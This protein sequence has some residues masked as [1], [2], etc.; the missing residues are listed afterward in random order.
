MSF[1][2]NIVSNAVS[3][4]IGKGIQDAVGKAVEGAV[5]PAADKLA[6]KAAEQVNEAAKGVELSTQAIKDAN[7]DLAA[8]MQGAGAAASAAPAG[9][10]GVAAA[11]GSGFAGLEAAF[12]GWASAAQNFAGQVAA[13]VKQCPKCGEV[14]TADHKFCP[15]CGAA[16]PEETL[17]AGYCCPKCGK[18]NLPETTY[19]VECGTLLP[20]AEAA[21]KAA[22]AKWEADLPQYPKWT[23][24][25]NVDIDGGN[26][27]NGYP[28]YS[29]HV[30]G[31]GREELDAYVNMLKNDGFIPAYDGDSDFYYKVV[32]GVCR[33]FDKTDAD[34]GDFLSM[35]F[36]VGDFDKKAEAKAK[37]EAE[38]AE[39]KAKAD[40]TIDAAK[41]KAG[42]LFGDAKD[43]A[44]ALFGAAKE[45]APDALDG[46]K[47]AADAAKEAAKGLFKKLF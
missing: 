8:G 4:G 1:L 16:L 33:S 18:Q 42:A 44:G 45:K 35:S 21:Q 15:K 25:G 38:L 20:A 29:V 3:D 5:K 11:P 17:G 24:K 40:A 41:E 10:A 9:A 37:A 28:C 26:T 6:G 32:D 2:K 12:S 47:E 39:A 27:L 22:L 19:C 36:F 43:K 46:A 34:Q 31:A 30:G 14:V 23:L 7:A 13:N